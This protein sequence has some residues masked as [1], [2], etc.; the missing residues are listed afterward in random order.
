MLPPMAKIID[1]IMER[2]P[3]FTTGASKSIVNDE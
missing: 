3:T 1:K 2:N